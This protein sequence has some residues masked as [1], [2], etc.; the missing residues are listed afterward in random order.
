M[1]TQRM[2]ENISNHTYSKSSI[3]GA[4]LW[5]SGS[6]STRFTG[7]GSRV[8]IPGV[9]LLHTPAT[10]WRCPTYKKSAAGLTRMLGQG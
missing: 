8:E 6:S 4:A 1:T 7:R 3:Q 2:G 5:L 10:L 9:H